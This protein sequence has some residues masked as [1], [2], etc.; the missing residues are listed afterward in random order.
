MIDDDR[1]RVGRSG[2][3]QAQS[4]YRAW[5][6]SACGQRQDGAQFHH[7]VAGQGSAWSKSC[8][9]CTAKRLEELGP[10]TETEPDQAWQPELF[11]T[12]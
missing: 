2:F 12:S 1:V 11:A 9:P 5:T 7:R 10:E 3:L 8:E 4:R 6:C